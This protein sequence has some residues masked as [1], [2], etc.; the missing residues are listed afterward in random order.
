MTRRAPEVNKTRVD[1][2]KVW[3][4]YDKTKWV[5]HLEDID[6]DTIKLLVESKLRIATGKKCMKDECMICSKEEYVCVR[7]GRCE[8]CHG[9]SFEVKSNG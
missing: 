2:D 1:W 9:H 3:S 6:K 7:C 8:S 4:I 5:I